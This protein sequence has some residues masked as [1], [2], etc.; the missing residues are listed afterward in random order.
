MIKS[1]MVVAVE[2]AAAAAAN[3]AAALSWGVMFA[4][5]AINWLKVKFD[6]C[7]SF[8]KQTLNTTT[9]TMLLKTLTTLMKN[10]DE[11]LFVNTLS[12]IQTH[13][14]LNDKL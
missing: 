7:V 11:K 8:A 10:I 1:V 13:A 6:S 14:C 5:V 9:T 3:T 12:L 2:A 4:I